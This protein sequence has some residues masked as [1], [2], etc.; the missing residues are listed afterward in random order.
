MFVS[1]P[2]IGFLTA[3]HVY[4]KFGMGNI[5]IHMYGTIHV[6][7]HPFLLIINSTLFKNINELLCL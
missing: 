6:H 7:I 3:L 1:G 5:H 4:L 2:S